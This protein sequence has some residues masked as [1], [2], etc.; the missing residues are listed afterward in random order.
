MLKTLSFILMLTI[1][2]VTTNAQFYNGSYQ[3]FG[4]NRVQYKGFEWRFHHYQKFKVYYYSGGENIAAYA[5]RSVDKHLKELQKFFEFNL[6]DKIDILVFNRQSDYKMS[7]IGITTD[8]STNIGGVTRISGS[9]LFVYYEGDH[10]SFEEQIRAG[11]S[12]IMVQKML[13][14]DNWKDAIKSSTL[15]SMPSWYTE[16]FTAY[17]GKGWN[18]KIDNQ[19]KDGILSGRYTQFNKLEGRDAELAGHS[20]WNFIAEKYGAKVLP[21]IFYMARISRNIESGFLFVL[22]MNLSTLSNEYINFYKKRYLADNQSQLDV[23]FEELPIKQLKNAVYTQY[24]ISPNGRYAAYVTNQLGQYKIWIYDIGEGKAKRIY[25]KD[26]KLDRTTD[27]SYPVINWHPTLN[28][29][30]FFTEFKGFLNMEIYTLDDGETTKLPLNNMDKVLDFAYNDDGTSIVL[31]GVNQGKTDLYLLKGVSRARVQLTDDIYDDLHPSF[32]EGTDKIIFSSNRP[33]DTIQKPRKAK[34][35]QLIGGDYDI[36]IYDVKKKN[37]R[38]ILQQITDTDDA[39]EFHPCKYDKINFSYISDR[40]G[41]FNRYVAK[42]D[43]A[44]AYIDTVIHYRYFSNEYALSN[45]KYNVL[46]YDMHAPSGRIG[47][48]TFADGKYHFYK[49]KSDADKPFDPSL[50]KHTRYI[51]ETSGKPKMKDNP[52]EKE[53]IKVGKESSEGDDINID[54]YEFEDDAPEFEKEVIKLDE[55]TNTKAEEKKIAK[56]EAKDAQPAF[57]LPPYQLY[58]TNFAIDYLV[59]QLDNNFL[60]QSYQRYAGPGAVFYNPGFNGLVKQG[61]PTYLKITKF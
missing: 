23:D 42:Y 26:Y 44:I 58:K 5:A 21:Q 3:E 22:G 19:V 36:F 9:K 28:A 30:T 4:K 43:S 11:I 55:I 40:N 24:K 7:N 16:G 46:Q 41:V 47:F 60:F 18:T 29:L 2:G 61:C 6:S 27:Y 57:K 59:T 33:G 38:Q 35:T 32:V 50:L 25:K 31:S 39:D 48:M 49:S 56:T 10:R 54:H 15:L 13:Y 37:R 1:A 34:E 20:V 53:T 17:L 52:F 12:E 45:Y 8:E 14:G 51:A